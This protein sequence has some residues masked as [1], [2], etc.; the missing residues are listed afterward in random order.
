MKFEK[1]V[2]GVIFVE[3][4]FE[5]LLLLAYEYIVHISLYKVL[6]RKAEVAVSTRRYCIKLIAMKLFLI[7]MLSMYKVVH[8]SFGD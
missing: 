1:T 6:D 8:R 2:F 7:F 3:L 5:S 4:R